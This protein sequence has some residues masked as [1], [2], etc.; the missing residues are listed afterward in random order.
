MDITF[1]IFD[2]RT[3]NHYLHLFRQHRAPEGQTSEESIFAG[4]YFQYMATSI[5]K[6]VKNG[7]AME[8][9]PGQTK[10]LCQSKFAELLSS[11]WKKMWQKK[12]GYS[13]L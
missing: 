6:K 12:G 5:A 10:L 7:E 8:Y 3:R 1:F 11:S 9:E 4:K 13:D 2:S